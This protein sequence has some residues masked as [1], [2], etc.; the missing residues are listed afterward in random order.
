MSLDA[1]IDSEPVEPR[2]QPRGHHGLG[3]RVE[4]LGFRFQGLGFRG[5]ILGIYIEGP[6]LFSKTPK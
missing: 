6:P 2:P 5:I 3:F 4:G 1:R